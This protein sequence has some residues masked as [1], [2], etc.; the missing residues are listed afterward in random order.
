M[1]LTYVDELPER[2][3]KKPLQD[4]IEEFCESG[5]PFAKIEWTTDDYVDASS[6]YSSMHKAIGISKKPVK[7]EKHGDEVYLIKI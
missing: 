5:R 1:R 3:S 2:K 6:C 7:V 4:F